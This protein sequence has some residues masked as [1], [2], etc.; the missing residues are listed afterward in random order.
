MISSV[1]FINANNS[2]WRFQITPKKLLNFPITAETRIEWLKTYTLSLFQPLLRTERISNGYWASV[3]IERLFTR[4]VCLSWKVNKV[5]CILPE[6]KEPIIF[7]IDFVYDFQNRSNKNFLKKTF[8]LA[9]S[10][11]LRIMLS[12]QNGPIF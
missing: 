10:S 1:E 5:R 6:T 7:C 2:Y 11:R 12:I 4:Y 8:A 3:H 9:F